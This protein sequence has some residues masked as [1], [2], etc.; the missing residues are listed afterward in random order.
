MA[1]DINQLLAV[2][3]WQQFLGLFVWLVL[4]LGGLITIIVFIR[5]KIKYSYKGVVFRRRSNDPETGIP[6]ADMI[7]GKAGY[8]NK[9]N[10]RIFRIR[11]GAM[12]WQVVEIKKTPNPKYMNIRNTAYFMQYDEGQLVQVKVDLDWE[13]ALMKISPV[14][15]TTKA[16]AKL[17]LSEFNRIFTTSNRL[18]ENMGIF[19]MGFILV[20]GIV[21]FYFV[22]KAC[23]G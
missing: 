1:F 13:N 12:P 9:G 17:E 16:A 3:V 10:N 18:K 15:S 19:I 11:Y 20:A 8:F 23:G 4:G 2:G 14:D 7:Q 6:Q 21:A 22:S 5:Q